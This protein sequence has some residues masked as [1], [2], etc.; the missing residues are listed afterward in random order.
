MNIRMKSPW[1]VAA[2]VAAGVAVA[3]TAMARG[4][5]A[6]VQRGDRTQKM[7]MVK[8]RFEARVNQHFDALAERLALRDDQRP[9]WERFR[10]S[11]TRGVGERG[12]RVKREAAATAPERL[13]RMEKA[14]EARLE[15]IRATLVATEQFYA[16]LDEN[17]RKV[18]DAQRPQRHE[19]GKPHHHPRHPGHHDRG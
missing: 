8:E 18:F 7:A 3:G 12:E 10:A 17:Q 13:Q 2:L 4:D 15:R 16:V 6:E 9:A 14:A 5:C 1:I 19:G 11:V